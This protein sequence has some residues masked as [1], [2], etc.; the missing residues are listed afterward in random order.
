MKPWKIAAGIGVVLLAGFAYMTYV[1]TGIVQ[2]MP[3][4]Y[5]KNEEM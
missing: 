4:D 3:H 1:M 2:C 5:P